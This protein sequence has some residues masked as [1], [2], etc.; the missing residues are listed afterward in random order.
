[1]SM[2]TEWISSFSVMVLYFALYSFSG[3]VC[4]TIY[5]SLHERRYVRRGFLAG[6]YCPIY[7][8]GAMFVLH[9]SQPVSH[10]PL[11]VFVVTMLVASALEYI[12]GG[13]FEHAF[14]LRLWDYSSHR[15]NI[16][17]RVCLLNALLFGLLGLLAVYLVHPVAG[18]IVT[19]IP[20]EVQDVLGSLL[21]ALLL[22]DFLRSLAAVSDL[23]TKLHELRNDIQELKNLQRKYAWFD[24]D[25][26]PSSIERLREICAQDP[27]NET[28]ALILDHLTKLTRLKDESARFVRNYPTMKSL[29]LM[30]ELNTLRSRLDDRRELVTANARGRIAEFGATSATVHEKLRLNLTAVGLKTLAWTFV[31]GSAIGYFLCTLAGSA[32]SGELVSGQSVLYGPFA[33]L[34]G[35]VAIL[36]QLFAV[37]LAGKSDRRLFLGG[38]ILGSIV[39]CANR[40]LMERTIGVVLSGFG[41]G[42]A[43]FGGRLSLFDI[44]AW[45][46]FGVVTARYVV[47]RASN[48]L[49]RLPERQGTVLSFA[50]IFLLMCN[51][52]LSAGVFIRWSERHDAVPPRGAF[53]SYIDARYPDEML[54][55]T[56]PDAYFVERSGENR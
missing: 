33:P 34:Y 46:V 20:S 38:C 40:W 9:I 48:L 14:Q 24:K 37:P 21:F 54:D 1:M 2:S 4:E 49:G 55:K 44:L 35:L 8:F 5:C 41:F 39:Q 27:G 3:W 16:K 50:M 7:G 18:M 11:L 19:A 15:F 56:F 25:N 32:S 23:N 36:V 52:F 30:E 6:P 22:A 17:G 12:T 45:G 43:L 42:P 10:N 26:L 13:F 28:S 47:P 31:A 51:I 53:Q 29:A